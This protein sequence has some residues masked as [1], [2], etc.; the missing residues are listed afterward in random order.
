MGQAGGEDD[1]MFAQEESEKRESRR[2]W[3]IAIAVVATTMTLTAL[4]A[5]QGGCFLSYLTARSRSGGSSGAYQRLL[6]CRENWEEASVPNDPPS[7]EE[8]R[9]SA[10]AERRERLA[11]DGADLLRTACRAGKTTKRLPPT[12]S[13]LAKAAESANLDAKFCDC[14]VSVHQRQVYYLDVDPAS[15]D[16]AIR[17]LY[18]SP[19]TLGKVLA[20]DGVQQEVDACIR[21][22]ILVRTGVDP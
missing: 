5:S 10:W 12:L 6:D 8:A 17:K 15:A 13:K 19:E 21:P 11:E 14:V 1:D 3:L 20:D 18:A 22:S 9:A 16:E 4:D 2:I 7:E